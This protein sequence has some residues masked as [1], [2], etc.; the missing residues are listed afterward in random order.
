MGRDLALLELDREGL[1]A[2]VWTHSSLLKPD[3][4]VFGRGELI[5]IRGAAS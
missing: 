4:L 1:A 2:P 5:G 3:E